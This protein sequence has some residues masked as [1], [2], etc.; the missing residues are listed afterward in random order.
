MGIGEIGSEFDWLSNAPYQRSQENDYFEYD[1]VLK[2]RSGRDA[3]KAIAIECKERSVVLMPALCCES[4]VSPF[5]MNGY[6]V[7]FYKLNPDYTIDLRD[8]ESK[9]QKGCL[10]LYMAYFGIEP[11]N[12]YALKTLKQKFDAVLIE[13]RTQNALHKISLPLVADFVV[14][15]IRKWLAIADGGI[16]I[17]KNPIKLKAQK[18]DFFAT[19]RERAMKMKSQYLITGDQDIK[20][21]FR[22]ELDKAN[23]VLDQSPNA[24]GVSVDSESLLKQIDFAKVLT[25]RQNNVNTLKQGLTPLAYQGKISFITN[26]PEQSTLYFPV[27]L[28]ERDKVQSQLAKRGIYCPVIWPVPEQAKEVCSV[29]DMTEEKMLAIPCDQRY[30]KNDMEFII[31]QLVEAIDG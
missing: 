25:A 12:S 4:M 16:L 28:N 3:L 26:L 24:F 19:V 30:D 1:C 9:M 20:Q 8:L 27:L 2:F 31:K 7:V 10:L 11:I 14:I 5:L 13:D 6:E 21:Q 15:S 29:A 22:S 18:E 23:Q 17:S